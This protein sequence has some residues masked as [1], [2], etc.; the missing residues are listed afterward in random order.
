LS[1]SFRLR[2]CSLVTSLSVYVF[3]CHSD[4]M[5]TITFALLTLVSWISYVSSVPSL[6]VDFAPNAKAAKLGIR[7]AD[8]IRVLGTHYKMAK[9][10]LGSSEA[11]GKSLLFS[12][13]LGRSYD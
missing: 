13:F 1:S 3:L 7:G 10:F 2:R 4:T 8:V 11:P 6:K 9:A 5:W 12:S